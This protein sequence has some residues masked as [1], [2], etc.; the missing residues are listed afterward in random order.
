MLQA[1]V[2]TPAALQRLIHNGREVAGGT[3]LA[4]CGIGEG[5]TLHLAPPQPALWQGAQLLVR[6]MDRATIQCI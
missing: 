6:L 5:T 2:G 3:T 1:V 4:E